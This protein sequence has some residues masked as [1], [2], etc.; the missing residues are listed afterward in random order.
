MEYTELGRTGI[1]VSKLCV[2]CVSSGRADKVRAR[3]FGSGTSAQDISAWLE[4]AGITK[5]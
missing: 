2:G 1:N 3:R 5:Q 4:E